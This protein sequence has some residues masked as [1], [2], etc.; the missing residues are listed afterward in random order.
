MSE[1]KGDETSSTLP[2]SQS[3]KRRIPGACD[4]CK[5][6]KGNSFQSLPGYKTFFG[7]IA[8]II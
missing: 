8:D 4:I 3:K 1:S 2:E 7:Y 5:R 6:K